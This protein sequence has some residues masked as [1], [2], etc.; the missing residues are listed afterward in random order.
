MN[1]G[2]RIQGIGFMIW[3]LRFR[4]DYLGFRVMGIR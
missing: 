1:S 4:I 2:F 3:D